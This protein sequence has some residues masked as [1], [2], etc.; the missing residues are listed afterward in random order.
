MRQ[1]GPIGR[2]NASP[3]A[4]T[5]LMGVIFS[6]SVG[7]PLIARAHLLRRSAMDRSTTIGRERDVLA[8]AAL[9]HRSPPGRGSLEVGH[10]HHRR[11]TGSSPTSPPPIRKRRSYGRLTPTQAPPN[12]AS[13]HNTGS[14]VANMS[15]SRRPAGTTIPAP[16][17][18]TCA[19]RYPPGWSLATGVETTRSFRRARRA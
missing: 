1:F 10:G 5:W 13:A 11:T 19:S 3:R 16:P 12:D 15:F 2:S 17:A 18:R 7:A 9:S 4:A 6:R 14:T 8:D